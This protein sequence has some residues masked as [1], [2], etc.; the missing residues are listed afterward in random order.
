MQCKYLNPQSQEQCNA[1]AMTDSEFCFVHN[2]DTKEQHLESAHRGGMA[3]YEKGLITLEPLELTDPKMIV[4]LLVDTINRARK[5]EPDGSM[6]IK[7][8]NCIA[9]LASKMIEAQKLISIEERLKRLENNL[10][11]SRVS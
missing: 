5:V 1:N 3:T 7:R 4:Y 6:S 11:Q 8:A 2:P 10:I 9:N